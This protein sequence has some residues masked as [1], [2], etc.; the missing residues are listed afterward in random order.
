MLRKSAKINPEGLNDPSKACPMNHLSDDHFN[1]SHRRNL[2]EH[3]TATR[4]PVL[5]LSPSHH[6][7]CPLKLNYFF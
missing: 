1:H 2:S 5:S 4:S 3:K 7:M 6:M